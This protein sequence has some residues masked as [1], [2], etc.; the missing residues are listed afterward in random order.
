LN[1]LYAKNIYYK[2]SMIT[3]VLSEILSV[4]IYPLIEYLNN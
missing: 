4:F 1:P 3:P 2:Q